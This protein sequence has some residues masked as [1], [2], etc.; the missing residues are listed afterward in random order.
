[1]N[2]AFD[3]ATI[4]LVGNHDS[5]V[6]KLNEV[7]AFIFDW[8]GVF[9]TGEKDFELQSRFNEIDSMGTNLLRFAFY[10]KNK[11]LPLS[12]IISGENNK[13]AFTFTNRECFHSN[14]FK[15]ANKIDAALHFCL[16]HNC[17]LSQLAFVFD[18]VLDFSIASQC[19]LRVFISRD[20]APA[21]SDYVI[22]NNLADIIIKADAGSNPVRHICEFLI[23]AYGLFDEV[24]AQRV[25]YSVNYKNY[26]DLRRSIKPVYYTVKNGTITETTI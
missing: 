26:I 4:K 9:T 12:A 19:G 10:L 3:N 6:T 20:S 1:M 21:L 11:H 8:D 16:T 14:Y 7:K 22:K 13:A 24:I 2:K 25:S 23:D 5:I 18:D 15:I 17:T